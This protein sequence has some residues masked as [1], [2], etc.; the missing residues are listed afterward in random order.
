MSKRDFFLGLE[1]QQERFQRPRISLEEQQ[2][3]VIESMEAQH[4]MEVIGA[5][6]DRSYETLGTLDDLALAM[7]KI[8]D[9][10][11]DEQTAELVELV[12]RAATAGTDLDSTDLVPALESIE[13]TKKFSVSVESIKEKARKL[14]EWIVAQIKKFVN[15]VKSFFGGA[16][17]R[18]EAVAQKLDDLAD[19]FDAMI[20]N[21]GASSTPASATVD[22][23][24]K[25]A[26]DLNKETQQHTENLKKS[27]ARPKNMVKIPGSL[28]YGGKP[29]GSI[30]EL[31]QQLKEFVEFSNAVHASFE[32]FKLPNSGPIKAMTSL[33]GTSG[34][35]MHQIA[36]KLADTAGNYNDSLHQEMTRSVAGL[37]KWTAAKQ[38]KDGFVYYEPVGELL[39]GGQL[40]GRIAVKEH[41][42][43]EDSHDVADR[44]AKSHFAFDLGEAKSGQDV[45]VESPSLAEA[46]QLVKLTVDLIAKRLKAKHENI[47]RRLAETIEEFDRYLKQYEAEVAAYSAKEDNEPLPALLVSNYARTIASY[48]ATLLQWYRQPWPAVMNQLVRIEEQV[49]AVFDRIH[50]MRKKDIVDHLKRT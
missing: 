25:S 35:Q 3:A 34:V 9:E 30:K 19:S 22:E 6:I 31:V 7:N 48:P 16:Q 24:V 12:G 47:D 42:Q 44:L 18:E 27:T 2:E 4:Q 32:N 40:H 20:R 17:K 1:S 8:E 33:A 23:Y 39:G 5:D 28:T 36:N 13:G 21:G 38:K 14:W 26:D 11:A 41:L 50:E 10:G 49:A 29:A 37:S 15:W 43:N 46:A 45:E